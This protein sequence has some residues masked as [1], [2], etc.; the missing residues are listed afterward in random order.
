MDEI[1]KLWLINIAITGT[2]AT[3]VGWIV[4][5]IYRWGCCRQVYRF[6]LHDPKD[7]E[8]F[9]T[10]VLSTYYRSPEVMAHQAMPNVPVKNYI[11]RSNCVVR[12]V[13]DVHNEW[14]TCMQN[15]TKKLHRWYDCQAY[16][17]DAADELTKA[18]RD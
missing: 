6:E 18:L 1:T 10:R 14:I 8:R 12:M 13:Y 11:L 3:V 5:E 7:I 9:E 15:G 2:I 17:W 16:G 4:C